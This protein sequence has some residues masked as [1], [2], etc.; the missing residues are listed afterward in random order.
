MERPKPFASR[1]FI[2]PAMPFKTHLHR[3]EKARNPPDFLGFSVPAMVAPLLSSWP[4]A[5]NHLLSASASSRARYRMRFCAFGE[6]E[7]RRTHLRYGE[8]N[9][10]PGIA[11][12]TS[13]SRH[14][15]L[16]SDDHL[17][18]SDEL[19]CSKSCGDSYACREGVWSYIF[20]SHATSSAPSGG[21]PLSRYFHNAT[22]S[23]RAMAT[24]PIRRRR[25]PP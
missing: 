9:T 10:C 12:R 19:I 11:R 8:F 1:P 13:P 2:C 14:G 20:F 25:L 6:P 15:N 22:N 4:K 23:F 24:I 17:P 5:S 21:T 3:R 18:F 7:R 16:D